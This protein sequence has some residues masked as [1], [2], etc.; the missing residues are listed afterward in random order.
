MDLWSSFW[1]RSAILNEETVPGVSNSAVPLSSTTYDHWTLLTTSSHFKNLVMLPGRKN[2]I[3]KNDHSKNYADGLRLKYRETER[4]M[5]ENKNTNTKKAKRPIHQS[6][7]E[8]R[9]VKQRQEDKTQTAPAVDEKDK[10]A[11][12]KP[13]RSHQRTKRF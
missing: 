4:Q 8:K 5:D 10:E 1:P 2:F 7:E 9:R 13:N 3:S 6:R 11:K 12:K